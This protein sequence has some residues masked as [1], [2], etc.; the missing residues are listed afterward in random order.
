MCH[1]QRPKNARLLTAMGERGLTARQLAAS[2]G[3]SPGTISRLLNRRA[4]A[5]DETAQRI[6]RALGVEPSTLQLVEG[7]P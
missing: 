7:Q 4:T 6:S 1:R 5:T 3:V 2:T